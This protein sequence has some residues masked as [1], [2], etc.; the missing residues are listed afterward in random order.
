MGAV[1]EAGRDAVDRDL[2]RD[3]RPLELA[4]GRDRVGRMVREPDGAAAARDIERVGD[5]QTGA[6][7]LENCPP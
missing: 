1:T 2:P 6:V 5:R 3:Q 7:E 4:A